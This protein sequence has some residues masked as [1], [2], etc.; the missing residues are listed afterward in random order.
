MLGSGNYV[1]KLNSELQRKGYEFEVVSTP[2]HVAR[3]GCG[4]CLKF[5]EEYFEMVRDEAD[6]IKTPV[7]EAFRVI[8]GFNK[9]KYERI[10]LRDSH[11]NYVE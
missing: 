6:E 4:L 8:P 9:N 5:P 1:Y 3:G 2:C 10:E 7:K 11:K